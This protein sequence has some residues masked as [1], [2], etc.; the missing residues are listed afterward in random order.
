MAAEKAGR[1]TSGSRLGPLS[2][3]LIHLFMGF[4]DA[5]KRWR[6]A[7]KGMSSGKKRRK[8]AT[9]ESPVVHSIERS[10]WIKMLIYPVFCFLSCLSV[11]LHEVD[12]SLFYDDT[13]RRLLVCVIVSVVGVLFYHIRQP[14]DVRNGKVILIFGGILVHLLLL[15]TTF[16]FI[17]T[18]GWNE[19]YRLLMAP[20]ALAPMVHSVLLG[21]HAGV[22]SAIMVSL[23]GSLLVPVGDIYSFI[24]ISFTTGG[25]AVA[26]TRSVRR[27]SD[28]LRA[29]LYVGAVSLLLVL[30]FDKIQFQTLPTHDELPIEVA[31]LALALLS[32]IGTAMVVSGLLPVLE[33]LFMITTNISWLELSDLNHKLLRKLQLEAPGTY[34][35]S[36][37]VAT[38]S[39]SAAEAIGANAAMCRV[40]SYFHDIGKL[41]KPNYFIENQG[42]SNPHDEL[43]PTMSTIIIIAHV[44]DGVDMAIKNKLNRKIIEVIREHHGTSVMR[45]FYHK[46]L[47]QRQEAEDKVEQGLAG[48]EDMPDVDLKGFRYP[49]PCPSSRES[50]IISLADIVES[51]S[52]TLKKPNPNRIHKLVNELVMARVTSGQLDD[53]DLTMGEIK[54]VCGSFSSTLISMMHSRVDYPE[55]GDKEK[56]AKREH[57]VES[58]VVEDNLPP[59]L[60][61]AGKIQVPVQ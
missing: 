4:I 21:R 33:A 57:P 16:Y 19:D 10:I 39:E 22:F 9:S 47:E 59:D 12:G 49:G 6:L 34:H 29:G 51:A 53:S 26:L 3:H 46:A 2:I 13:F 8:A 28:L 48:K 11:G 17:A 43:T 37:V 60:S 54:A 27:R 1:R 32:G 40:C 56:K 52:R 5:F 18:N 58:E 38:L 50:G 25:I 55:D 35:H 20:L 31:K 7:E 36:M 14:S 15:R 45:Y 41:A 44:K 42:D 23:F 61:L 24:I 30:A